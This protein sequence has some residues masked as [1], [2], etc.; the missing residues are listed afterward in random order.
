MKNVAN[1]WLSSMADLAN[2]QP[3]PVIRNV[4]TQSRSSNQLMS[5]ALIAAKISWQERVR[6]VV[7]FMDAAVIPNASSLIGISRSTGNARNAVHFLLR[8]KLKRVSMRA[9]TASA[10]IKKNRSFIN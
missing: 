3:V 6:L 5:N 9:L 2:L 8:K 1:R 10:I 7:F 4:R